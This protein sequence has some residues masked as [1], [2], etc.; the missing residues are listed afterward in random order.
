MPGALDAAPGDGVAA[1]AADGV[2]AAAGEGVVA[3][4]GGGVIAAAA[5][6]TRAVASASAAQKETPR[7][8]KGPPMRNLT[9]EPVL[10]FRRM[11]GGDRREAH[12]LLLELLTHDDYYHDSRAAYAGDKGDRAGAEAALGAALTLFLDRPDYGFVWMSFEGERAVGCALVS[13]AISPALGEIVA[14]LEGVIVAPGQR[15]R[16]IGTQMLDALAGQLKAAEIA[17]LDVSVNIRNAP[18]RAFCTTLGFEPT[19]E[20]RY[21]FLL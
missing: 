12:D 8:A 2:V 6:P 15:R 16:G 9:S 21:A 13:Y 7:W 5:R 11:T 1:A 18:G 3:A 19:Y 17:R 14:H 20:E 10:H 4:A